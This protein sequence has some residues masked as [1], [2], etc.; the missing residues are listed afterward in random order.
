MQQKIEKHS[1]PCLIAQQRQEL[2]CG[3][4]STCKLYK[5][6]TPTMIEAHIVLAKADDCAQRLR[7]MKQQL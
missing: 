2:L 7:S 1:R 6:A 3:T 5:A 4:E